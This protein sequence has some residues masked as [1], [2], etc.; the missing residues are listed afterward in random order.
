MDLV[1][2]DILPP[3]RGPGGRRN[4]TQKAFFTSKPPFFPLYPFRHSALPLFP[5]IYNIL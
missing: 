2:I 5:K 4:V 1:S 3:F